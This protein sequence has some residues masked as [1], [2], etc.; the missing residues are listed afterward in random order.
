MN[1]LIPPH[2]GKLLPI[3]RKQK[4]GGILDSSEDVIAG[5]F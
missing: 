3:K 5:N 2:K 4:K 1:S